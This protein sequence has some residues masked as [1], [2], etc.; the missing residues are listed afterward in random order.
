MLCLFECVK[1]K[2]K[3]HL[4][5]C[6]SDGTYRTMKSRARKRLGIGEVDLEEIFAGDSLIILNVL[7]LFS[8][9]ISLTRCLML[10]KLPPM[11]A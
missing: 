10:L 1:Q 2:R 11:M 6:I 7:Y 3:Y 4:Y 8:I 9:S 5:F